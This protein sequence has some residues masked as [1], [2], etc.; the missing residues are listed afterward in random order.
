M[1]KIAE[2]RDSEQRSELSIPIPAAVKS[3]D[4]TEVITE[5][6]TVNQLTVIE[7]DMGTLVSFLPEENYK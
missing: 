5:D 4:Y 3:K 7:L 6:E 1:R 2:K